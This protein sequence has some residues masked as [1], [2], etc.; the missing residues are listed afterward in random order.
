MIHNKEPGIGVKHDP[1]V[2]NH[3][4]EIS[5]KMKLNAKLMPLAFGATDAAAFSKK[6]IPAVALGGL[7]LKDELPPY[8]HTRND[9][10][11]VIEKEA[12]GQIV[13]LCLEYL[14]ELDQ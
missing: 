7:N 13:D 8:Y 12:L 2:F 11:D 9:T 5:E 4:F 1:T 10:P 6:K 3:L 14:K